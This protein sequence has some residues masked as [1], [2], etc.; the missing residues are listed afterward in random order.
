LRLHH[1]LFVALT[2]I[3]GTPIAV[4]ALWE[5][6]TT[7]QNELDA[8]RERHLLVARNLTATL[9][10]Y[11]KDVEAIFGLA[12][13]SDALNHPVI[14][15]ADLLMSLDVI[16]VRRL[17]PD[18][19]LEAEIKDLSGELATDPP[20][21]LLADLRIL[22]AGEHGQIAISNLYHDPSG[23]PVFYL[24]KELPAGRLG[25]GVLTTRYLVSLQQAI[26]FGDHGHA[27]IVDA[28]GQVI[29]HPL[30][31]W[32]AA[33][34]DLSGE[35]VVAAMMRDE[36]GVGQFHAQA[37]G[38]TFGNDMIA[39]YALVPE[40][41]WGVVVPRPVGEL[42]RR[43]TK[44]NEMATMITLV[45]FGGAAL[46]AWLLALYLARPVR[47]VAD[48]AEA[49]LQGND[50][51]SVPAF[52]GLV[53]YEIHRLGA[54]FNTMLNDQRRRVAETRQA[55]LQAETSNTAKS[56]FLANMSHESAPP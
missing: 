24:V 55:L 23:T 17:A 19:T 56:Q 35:P 4:L 53:P 48:T 15:L 3:A 12:F 32:V 14:G 26:V 6:N 42:R 31:D 16:H 21:A 44:L 34:H 38:P 49:V 29:A 50:E 13:E 46:M 43:A 9:S 25:L 22:A 51:V 47:S 45:S 52:H 10:H 28:K 1:F 2:I 36:T 33:S 5:E 8:A 41:G 30:K 18:G 40:T 20:P 11:V 54:A 7:Y 39:A 37:F 27:V